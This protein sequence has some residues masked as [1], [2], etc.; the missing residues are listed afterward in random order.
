VHRLYGFAV[1]GVDYTAPTAIDIPWPRG[2][3]A[4]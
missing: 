1:P 3:A 4:G 2:H